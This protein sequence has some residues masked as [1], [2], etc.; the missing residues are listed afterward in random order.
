MVFWFSLLQPLPTLSYEMP[1]LPVPFSLNLCIPLLGSPSHSN[2]QHL[3]L[4]CGVQDP[5][6][7]PP[8]P[9]LAV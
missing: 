5:P 1:N 3:F 8:A 6:L 4:A 9:G 7:I 2:E